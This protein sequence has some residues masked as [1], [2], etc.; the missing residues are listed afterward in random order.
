MI[1]YI[2]DILTHFIIQVTEMLGYTGVAVLMAIESAAIPLPSEII[3]PFAGFVV[4]TG[5][6]NLW[7]VALAG[8]VGSAVGSA[9]TY[10]IGYYGG[11]P[12]VKKYG[13]YVFVSQHDLNLADRFFEKYG[14]LSTFIGRLLPVVRTFISVPAGIAKTPFWPFLWYSFFGSFLWSLLLAYVGMKLGP[15]WF[16]LREK[17][18]WIDYVIAVI[19]LVGGIWWIY[20]H[21][22]HRN[23]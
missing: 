15:Q 23:D 12:L 8:G 2:I 3:M 14:S 1:S 9:I 21:F 20:R 7:L 10:Y 22:K 18:H 13:K 4:S 17:V 6:F 11:R 5:K 19:I 16:E